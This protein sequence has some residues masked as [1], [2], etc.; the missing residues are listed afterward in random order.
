MKIKTI[1]IL[2]FLLILLLALFFILASLRY[3]IENYNYLNPND[4]SKD[5]MLSIDG[6]D[7]NEVIDLPYFTKKNTPEN[8]ISIEKQIP[9]DFIKNPYLKVGSSQQ[10]VKIY[11]DNTLI[12]KF[13]SMRAIN[14]NKTGGALWL[15]VDLPD[16]C[17]GKVLKIEFVSSYMKVSGNLTSVRI[18]SKVELLSELFF[19]SFPKAILSFSLFIL[20]ILFLIISIYYKKV[21]NINLNGHYI[22]LMFF[23]TSIWILAESQ[24]FVFIFNNYSLMYFLQFI[25]LFSFPIFLYKYIFLQYNMKNKKYIFIFFKIHFY[26]LLIFMLLQLIGLLSFYSSQWFFL[27]IFFITFSIC[28]IIIMFEF[29][30]EKKLKSL[31]NILIILFISFILDTLLYDFKL[32][33]FNISFLSLGI[34]LIEAYILIRVFRNISN[35][36]KI[37]ADNELLNLQLNYQL[38]YYH[39][40]KEKNLN[41]KSYKHDMLNHWNTVYI[42]INNNNIQD[43]KKYISNLINKFSNEKKTIIDTCNPVL[44]AILTEKIELAT[45]KNISVYTDIFINKNLKIDLLDFCIIFA[46]LLDNAIEATSKANN[47]KYIKIKLISKNNMLICKIIN[48]IDE[49]VHI[50][51]TFA[52]TKKDKSCHGIGLKNVTNAIKKYNGELSIDYTNFTFIVSFILLEV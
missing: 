40:I 6:T 32:Y 16:D 8:V 52:T 14:N 29:K 46:N 7:I 5:W 36:K 19:Q 12:Y 37:K 17:F 25:S 24:F 44:D 26:L 33:I 50:N 18:G 45:N 47:N 42:L 15:L 39:S 11:L 48:S 13:D 34:L 3:K 20:S 43:S 23:L 35:L 49:N 10:E 30:R 22:S 21:Y 28:M 31:I 38:K 51:K 2:T 27:F 4:F 1:N 41:L 9:N